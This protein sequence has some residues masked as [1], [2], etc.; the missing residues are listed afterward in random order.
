M[1][2]PG[3]PSDKPVEGRTD[4]GAVV[5]LIAIG[6]LIAP[7][8][9]IGTLRSHEPLADCRS[10]ALP[11]TPLEGKTRKAG[12]D[13]YLLADNG[14]HL[15]QSRCSGKVRQ[16]CL[17]ATDH[18]EEWLETHLGEIAQAHLCSQGMI[19]YTVAKRTFYR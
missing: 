12:Q 8:L 16:T 5:I 4:P 6:L 13:Y 9:L 15:L 18:A 10:G 11:V 3:S 2:E 19:D 17:E 14:W 7:L 1:A